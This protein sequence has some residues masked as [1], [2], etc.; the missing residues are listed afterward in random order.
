M[1]LCVAVDAQTVADKEGPQF[2]HQF[3]ACVLHR[4]ELTGEITVQPLLVAGAVDAL[5]RSG[6]KVCRLARE[7]LRM[8]Q[9]D[10]IAH[11]AVTG[12]IAPMCDGNLP[13]PDH[14]SSSAMAH[15]GGPFLSGVGALQD[16]AVQLLL[17]GVVR[18]CEA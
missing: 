14:F 9:V 13:G 11:W 15:D 3:L 12:T 1:I 2:C 5:V 4:A 17:C 18:C 6:G 16:Q 8:W 10:G 7:V